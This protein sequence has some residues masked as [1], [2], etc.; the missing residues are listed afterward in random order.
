MPF[1]TA[2]PAYPSASLV[3]IVALLAAIGSGYYAATALRVDT[4]TASLL[5]D[6]LPARV[7]NQRYRD[8][9][10]Q[11][12]PELVLIVEALTPEQAHLTAQRLVERLRQQPDR[13]SG[14]HRPDGHEFFRR[15]GL[16]YQNPE[17]LQRLSTRLTQTL[18]LLA[19]LNQNPSLAGLLQPLGLFVARAAP[20][21]PRLDA[22]LGEL[23]R[24][25]RAQ[26]AGE[27]GALSW[28]RLMRGA[29]GADHIARS[30]V[31]AQPGADFGKLAARGDAMRAL[32]DLLAQMGLAGDR[33]PRVRVT[34]EAA[35]AHEE[36]QTLLDG[37]LIGGPVAIG[38]VAIVLYFAL[39]SARMVISTLITL[40]LG[41][42]L[43]AGFA[44][45]AVGRLNLIS[46]AFALLYLGLGVDFAIHFL[47][48]YRALR[49]RGEARGAA[50]VHAIRQMTGTLSLC[51]L[52]TAL[53]FLAFV[54]TAF[55]GVAELGIIAGGGMII[56]LIV[57]LT[58][59]PAMLALGFARERRTTG[60]VAAPPWWQWLIER[61]VNHPVLVVT[62]TALCTAAG[63][64]LIP[65]ARFNT[66]PL[67]LRPPDSPAVQ[68]LRDLR[69]AEQADA[70]GGAIV[71]CDSAKR[72]RE[73]TAALREL[74]QVKRAIS[75]F[76][77]VPK[78]QPPKLAQI[79]QLGLLAEPSLSLTPERLTIEPVDEQ[80][81]AIRSFR[82]ALASSD[83]PRGR[84]H[85]SLSRW[86]DASDAMAPAQQ[87]AWV[88]DLHER[89]LGTL[90]AA[91]EGFAL[92]LRA[93]PVTLASMPAELK[94]HWISEQGTYRVQVSP[95][96]A[97]QTD[98]ARR[99][100][101]DAVAAV[102]PG[103]GGPV[104]IQVEA[105][106]AIVRAFVMALIY[107]A[108]GILVLLMMLMRSVR[109]SAVVLLPLICGGVMTVGAMV[110][111]RMPFNFANVIALPLLLG[112]GVD[113]G[114]HMV[115]R[116]R[117][118]MT[119]RA[120]LL[121]TSTA[122]GVL[123]SMLTTLCGFGGLALSPHPGTASMGIL[124]T[125][126]LLLIVGCT[127]ILLPA[128][129]QPRPEDAPDPTPP[130]AIPSDR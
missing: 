125:L 109:L 3:L 116:S 11:N 77:L 122:R 2:H 110:V 96:G 123:F 67:D 113:N 18:P 124:L 28:Q 6:E 78:D 64:L 114:I 38:L 31:L 88:A 97:M 46:V 71:L 45:V 22:M 1:T 83:G 26:L 9:F 120:G 79:Q 42:L 105:G 106:R 41:L 99:A 70:S 101:V 119:G 33:W 24:V 35:L 40:V 29:D 7:V 4:D 10:P 21:E 59:L 90:P 5:S 126:G 53:G 87:R 63:G 48:R 25:V 15:H 82:D 23:D 14:V 73:V 115:Q 61:P 60:K 108:A 37:M 32:D 72:A 127:L 30:I 98:A 85:D 43:T 39:R 36:M 94:S 129:L 66:D 112:V 102:A 128:M 49:R 56:G 19:M 86:L 104:V 54:P 100:F 52:T 69:A 92:A 80:I 57:T 103:A 121:A 130:A 91:M 93:G 50:R 16:L 75:V 27:P 118:A 117:R 12:S 17:E 95:A 13:F 8:L 44:T 34:G 20:D 55:I 65:M 107:A 111:L 68:A 84:L 89:V 58:V 47:L 76:D 81:A 51:A 62:V 74:P